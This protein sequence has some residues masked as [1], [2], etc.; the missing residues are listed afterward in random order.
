MT[1]L[2]EAS[3]ASLLLHRSRGGESRDGNFA[4]SDRDDLRAARER[5]KSRR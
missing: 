4:G 1:N 2:S 5:A 3:L